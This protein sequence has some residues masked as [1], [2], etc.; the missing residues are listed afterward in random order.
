MNIRKQIGGILSNKLLF[1][2]LFNIRKHIYIKIGSL[3]AVYAS[4]AEPVTYADRLKLEYKPIRPGG[5]WGGFFDC[6][7]FNFTGNILKEHLDKDL[8]VRINISGE[9]LIYDENGNPIKGLAK[10]LCVADAL[11]SVSGKHLFR[12][13]NPSEKLNFWVETGNN[14]FNGKSTGQAKFKKADIL[15]RN[16][17]IFDLYYDFLTLYLKLTI[18]DKKSI[19]AKALNLA[20]KKA[21][22]ILKDYND[23]EVNR[24]REILSAELIKTTPEDDKFT[25]YATGHAHLDLAWLWPVRETKRKAART[26]SNQLDLINNYPDYI[27]GASQP[28]QYQWMKDLYPAL[29]GQIKHAVNSG[30]IEAQGG[31]WVEA[32]TNVT[33]GESLVRQML[34]GKRF[35]KD[36]FDK[37][38]KILWLPDVFGFSGALP[39][40]IKKSGMDYFLTIKLSWNEHNKFPQHSFIWE[41]IDGSAVLVHMPPEGT[42]NSEANADAIIDAYNKYVEKHTNKAFLP[43]GVGDGGGGPGESHLEI[44]SREYDLEGIKKVKLST[45]EEFFRELE[46]DKSTLNSYQGELYLEKHQGTLTTQAKNKRYNRKI[47]ILLRN[48][49]LLASYAAEKGYTYPKEK[50]EN[51]WK[52]VLLYQFH[53]IIP[54]SSINRVYVESVKRYQEM[55]Q[56]LNAIYLDIT[57]RLSNGEAAFTAINTLQFER[58][59]WVKRDN[60]WYYAEIAP[61]SSAPLAQ[62]NPD[63]SSLSYSSDSIANDKLIISFSDDGSIRSLI[64]VNGRD[65][66]G[67]YLNRLAVYR[68]K[69]LYYNAWDID[70]NYTLKS[71]AYFKAESSETF[72]DGPRVIRRTSYA[73]HNSTLVQDVILISGLDYVIFD[74]K[75][76]WHEKH[77][78]LR[79]E[80]MPSVYSDKVLC[81]IQFG[82]IERSTRTDNPVA[83]AQF[84]I[85][86]H[87]YVDVS[88]EEAG[89]SL[90]NDC[91][92]GHRVKDG[93]ISLNLLRSPVFPDPEADRGSQEFVYALYPHRGGAFDSNLIE[94]AYAI[95]NPVMLSDYAVIIDKLFNIRGS[96]IILETVKAAEDADG[97]IIRLFETCGKPARVKFVASVKYAKAYECDMLENILS[98]INLDKLEFKPYEIKTILLKGNNQ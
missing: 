75:V 94:Y 51:I 25:F 22:S 63:S 35:F 4:T 6:A 77:K 14:G 80:F 29:Y 28:Q 81:D 5:K 45:A 40:I 55:I 32:D 72:I 62:K 82:N 74:T 47:E 68:D 2:K 31:M 8:W 66:C 93:L 34:Y 26:F 83:R 71:P 97:V 18:L 98:E 92:Y 46:M 43:F 54:G 64:D 85:C 88:S 30:R 90:I 56:E 9:G 15:I 27:F 12:L 58:K 36:E 95:N 17:N 89:I 3:D 19:H 21:A 24:A 11:G 44:I 78:M 67:D 86:A 37:D 1:K 20:L 39:Q 87:K 84:E 96:N 69:R 7:W 41:G 42:Y 53:D 13:N 49:E 52:E 10:F 23:D 79:A 33:G 65:Y 91:K 73:Y 61:F 76:D 60:R 59:E 38:M 16:K 57:A 50:I 70:I 48:I